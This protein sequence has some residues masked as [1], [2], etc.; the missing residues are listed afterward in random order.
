ML[1]LQKVPAGS[2][3]TGSSPSGLCIDTYHWYVFAAPLEV[4][5]VD[6]DDKADPPSLKSSE[7]APTVAESAMLEAPPSQV[8]LVAPTGVGI[9]PTGPSA[10]V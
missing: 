3:Q 9:E 6:D 4:I 7:R 1:R 8:N 5:H 10:L 2:F